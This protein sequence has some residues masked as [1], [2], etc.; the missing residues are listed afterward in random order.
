MESIQEKAK[1]RADSNQTLYEE[2]EKSR[3]QYISDVNSRFAEKADLAK[4]LI[5]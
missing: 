3:N 4:D 2:Y 1:K 5:S